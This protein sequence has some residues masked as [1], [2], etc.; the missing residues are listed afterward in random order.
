MD[1]GA[2]QATVHR[3]TQ[4]QTQ[5][6]WLSTYVCVC[7]YIYIYNIFIIYYCLST[8][9]LHSRPELGKRVS[10]STHSP[11]SK[12]GF[13]SQ[14]LWPESIIVSPDTGTDSSYPSLGPFNSFLKNFTPIGPYKSEAALDTDGHQYQRMIK[15][16][17][18][19]SREQLKLH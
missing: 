15:T 19:N 11:G 10:V 4:S 8:Y 16:S 17:L 18:F 9:S 1:R 7:I 14:K 13:K 6:K 3:V 2:W 12:D 5:L